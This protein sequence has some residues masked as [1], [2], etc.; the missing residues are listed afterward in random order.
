MNVIDILIVIALIGVVASLVLGIANLYRSSEKGNVR[1]NNLMR[2]RVIFQA[3]AI[4]LLVVGV[5]IKKSHM[6]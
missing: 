3:V 1:S 5:A 2:M 4:V 6:G